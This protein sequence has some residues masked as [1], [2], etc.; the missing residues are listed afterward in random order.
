VSEV[1]AGVSRAGQSEP[2]WSRTGDQ[3]AARA[4]MAVLQ[5]FRALEQADSELAPQQYQ[6]MKLAGV[7]GERSVRLAE[8]L[9]A[10]QPTLTATAARDSRPAR[11]R[12]A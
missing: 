10:A 9:A 3:R 12:P 5:L 7:G 6:I 8:R 2:G 1:P 11:A 4:A